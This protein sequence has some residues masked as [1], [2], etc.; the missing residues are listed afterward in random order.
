MRNLMDVNAPSHLKRWCPST[1]PAR[2][3]FDVCGGDGCAYW[4]F[5]LPEFAEGA[6]SKELDLGY[7]AIAGIPDEVMILRRDVVMRGLGDYQKTSIWFRPI[8]FGWIA[9]WFRS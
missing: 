4:R 7:C 9:R 1:G 5:V 8:S 2:E 3:P 6:T